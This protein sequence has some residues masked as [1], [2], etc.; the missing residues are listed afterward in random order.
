VCY[1]DVRN[2]YLNV[3]EINLKFEKIKYGIGFV[4][5]NGKFVPS[6]ATKTYREV[7]VELHPFLTLA[8]YAGGW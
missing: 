5:R 7:A 3:I 8:L 6:H 2:L 4:N 1:C